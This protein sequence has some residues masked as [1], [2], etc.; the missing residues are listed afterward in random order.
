MA[1]RLTH[2][3]TFLRVAERGSLTAAARDLS[4]SQPTVTRAIAALEAELG[5][6]LFHRTTHSLAL[7][8]RGHDLLPRA[9]RLL[10]A[11]DGIAEDLAEGDALSG[12][13]HVI[14][15]IALGQTEL[16]PVL[17]A[18]RA[19]HPDVPVNWQLTDAPVRLSETGAD[20]WIR[21]GPVPDDTLVQR[22][23]GRVDRHV[24]GAPAFADVPLETCPWIT[25]G[26]YEGRHI[27]LQ[28]RTLDVA[29]VLNTNSIAVA[30]RAMAAGLGVAIAPD[31]Y[32][33]DDVAAGRIARLGP[34]A[35]SLP[36]HLAFAPERRTRRLDAFMAAVTERLRDRI[37]A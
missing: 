14:A 27:A 6:P 13:L 30:V 35:A 15:P 25:V 19:A 2:L 26:P 33:R 9:R 28:G 11:W 12:P 21:V 32:V 1:D 17:T 22:E 7:T 31:W 4:V 16:I 29:P 8:E 24:Y 37:L 20:L 34:P 23:V 10:A 36:V 3:A 18:F 5:V